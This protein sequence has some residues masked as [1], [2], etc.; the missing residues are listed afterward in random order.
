M[1]GAAFLI[2]SPRLPGWRRLPRQGY[3][4]MRL[5]ASYPPFLTMIGMMMSE[6]SVG[7]LIIPYSGRSSRPRQRVECVI[8]RR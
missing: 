8:R 6:M 7:S 5:L 3:E 4:G 1:I 2:W